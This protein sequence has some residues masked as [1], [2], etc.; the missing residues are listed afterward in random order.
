MNKIYTITLSF[1]GWQLA[2]ILLVVIVAIIVI[3]K[4]VFP[5]REDMWDEIARHERENENYFI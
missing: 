4:I 1:S 3:A 5:K 2:L